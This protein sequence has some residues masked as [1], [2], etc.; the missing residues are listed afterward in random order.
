MNDPHVVELIYR[1]EHHD[2]V[3]YRNATPLV[4]DQPDF[5]LR[6]Q[7]G[8]AHFGLK[9]HYATPEGARNSVEK[10]IRAWEFDA[11]LTYGPDAFSLAFE[12]FKIIDRDPTPGV[13]EL[14]AG[15]YVAAAATSSAQL[16]VAHSVYPPPPSDI[17]VSPDA[18]VLW[19]RFMM[20]RSD[21]EPL[22]SMAYF[23]LSMLE[24]LAVQVDPNETPRRTKRRRAAADKFRIGLEL[25]SQIGRLSSARGARKA[26]SDKDFSR[27]ER[28][29]LVLALKRAI[30]RVAELAHD[31][32]KDLERV[33][34]DSIVSAVAAR[35]AV[36]EDEV[37]RELFQR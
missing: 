21:R 26:E 1:V 27:V 36:R 17:V 18:E 13:V 33:A 28:E 31:S 16:T 24:N 9:R 32:E 12:D 19:Q 15:S 3:D 10:Y 6:V 35:L 23:C 4:C 25:L 37:Q 8:R 11:C 7:G 34:C 20:Y 14:Y 22:A 29:F 2:G 5:E 30:R